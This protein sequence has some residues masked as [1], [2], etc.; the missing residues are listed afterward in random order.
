MDRNQM[1]GVNEMDVSSPV[2][3]KIWRVGVL[4]A[5]TLMVLPTAPRSE[6]DIPAEA[7]TKGCAPTSLRARSVFKLVNRS[8][9]PVE[10]TVN[11]FKTHA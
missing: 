9:R 6:E 1:D 7:R 3:T 10:K 2:S 11:L 8:V 4:D 5:D